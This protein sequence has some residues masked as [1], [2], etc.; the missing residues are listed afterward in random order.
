MAEHAK[1]QHSPIKFVTAFNDFQNA[2]AAIERQAWPGINEAVAKLKASA[3]VLRPD[4]FTCKLEARLRQEKKEFW[5][6]IYEKVPPVWQG[7][8]AD[9]NS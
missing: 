8:R 2:L 1:R 3:E 4:Y 6:Y 9:G 7:G 5:D